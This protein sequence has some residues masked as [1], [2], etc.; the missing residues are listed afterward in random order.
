[1]GVF[2]AIR[3]GDD[4]LDLTEAKIG[5]QTKI[6]QLIEQLDQ[7]KD[8]VGDAIKD[9]LAQLE[10]AQE[11]LMSIVENL[12][13][14]MGCGQDEED[15]EEPKGSPRLNASIPAVSP[16]HGASILQ[17]FPIADSVKSHQLSIEEK[18]K[19]VDLLGGEDKGLKGNVS[20]KEQADRPM[21]TVHSGPH[22]PPYIATIGGAGMSG[23]T[24]APPIT[25]I[26]VKVNPLVHYSSARVLG[27]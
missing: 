27:V 19:F 10:K 23:A 18:G 15:N 4:G 22:L 16:T 3:K 5:T 2:I 17:M 21:Y 26:K 6:Q 20:A 1:M 13:T 9:H 25:A 24:S 7:A 14:E 8:I 12:T 11:G